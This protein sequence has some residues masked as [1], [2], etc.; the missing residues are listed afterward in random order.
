MMQYYLVRRDYQNADNYW[1]LSPPLDQNGDYWRSVWEFSKGNQVVGNCNG[2]KFKVTRVAKPSDICIGPYGTIVVRKESYFPFELVATDAQFFDA[3]IDC[4]ESV[5][6][7]NL[8]HTIDCLDRDRS[9]IEYRSGQATNIVKII[10]NE[11][12]LS[13]HH[14]FRITGLQAIGFVID[15][16][17]Y[18]RLVDAKIT[19]VNYELLEV[20]RISNPT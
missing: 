19:G 14:I 10:L 18:Q 8:V 12:R 20:S 11:S 9:K 2:L 4:Y 16:I 5:Y 6:V 13:G 7:L 17:V 15:E 3:A 1:Y